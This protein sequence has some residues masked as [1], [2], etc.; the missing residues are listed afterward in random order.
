MNEGQ[1]EKDE[2]TTENH[3]EKEKYQETRRRRRREKIAWAMGWPRETK[4]EKV[5][6]EIHK[7]KNKEKK[8]EDQQRYL[9]YLPFLMP[10][11]R[12]MSSRTC[13]SGPGARTVCVAGGGIGRTCADEMKKT[14]ASR[15]FP[16]ITSSY[17]TRTPTRRKTRW[18]SW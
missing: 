12:S 2:E 4:E 15:R 6:Q 17:L 3:G 7:A 1:K 10:S 8:A 9:E 16:W 18:W 14:T 13:R 11:V 5:K